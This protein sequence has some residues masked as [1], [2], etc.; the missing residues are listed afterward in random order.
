[1]TEDLNKAVKT[2]KSGGTILYPTDTI[3]GIGCDATNSK[4]VDKIYAIKERSK[5]SRFIILLDSPN[6]VLDYV[7]EVP[8]ILWDLLK[9]ID[10]PTTIIY[11]GAKNLPKN[12]ISKDGT[13]A[14]RIVKHEFCQK[15]IHS[16]NKPIIS[17]S[18]NFSSEPSPVVF[19]EISEELKE[20]VDYIVQTGRDKMNK[21][22]GS[23]IIKIKMNGEFEIIRP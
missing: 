22:K 2:I 9:N 4:A 19:Q 10:S 21:S 15:L 20:K 13:I 17:T 16:L 8:D 12:V 23:T 3:W 14:I 7:K 5:L 18:A 11:P 1:M 6:K